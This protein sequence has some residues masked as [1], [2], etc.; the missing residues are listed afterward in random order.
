MAHRQPPVLVLAALIATGVVAVQALLVALFAWPAANAEPRDLPVV[1]AGPTPAVEQLAGQLRAA[2]PGAFDITTAPDAAAADQA[3]RDRDAYAAFVV[4]PGGVSLHTAS[5]A[6]PAVAQLLTQ[7]A[8]QLGGQQVPVTDV[9]PTDADDPHGGG[10]GAGFLPL[11]ITSLVVGTVLVVAVRSRSGRLV[12]LVAYAVL[13]GLVATL[14]LQQWLGVLPDHYLAGAAAIGLFALAAGATVAGLG[15]LLG[16]PGIGLGALLVFL[17]ATPLSGLNGAPELL[18]EP[19]GEVGQWL[20]VGAG[21]SLLRSAAYFDWAG[22]NQPVS[23]LVGSAVAGL[24]LVVAGRPG[25]RHGSAGVVAAPRRQ[26]PVPA[27]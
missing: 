18:P 25:R 22:A 7:A 19:W 13:A 2:R 14:V 23:V 17:V 15:S 21:G 16:Y 10:F 1:V 24:A 11:A 5:A 26:D 20:P 27:A 8:G 3:L 9:V 6:S 12:G 4:D